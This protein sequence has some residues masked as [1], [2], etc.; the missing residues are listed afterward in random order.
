MEAVDYIK[1]ST[2]Y[3]EPLKLW[4][5]EVYKKNTLITKQEQSLICELIRRKKPKKILE[6]GVHSGGTSAVIL[7][8]IET[9][10]ID[11]K[12]YSVD[13]AEDIG[14]GPVGFVVSSC[15]VHF[16]TQNW[17]LYTGHTIAEVID[18]IGENIDLLVLDAAHILPGEC[19]DFLT[20]YP[21]LSANAMVVTHDIF[22]SSNSY[23]TKDWNATA[24]LY[25]TVVADKYLLIDDSMDPDSRVLCNIGA[26]Q[27]NE[28]TGKYIENIFEGLHLSWFCIPP[29][30]CV[31]A[32]LKIIKENYPFIL[33]DRLFQT[34]HFNLRKRKRETYFDWNKLLNIKQSGT[35]YI[36]IW[37]IK[38]L[39]GRLH[40]TLREYLDDC[41]LKG[42][43]S[44]KNE[45][46]AKLLAS[47]CFVDNNLTN[48]DT[49]LLNS[50]K[51]KNLLKDS[52]NFC[53]VIIGAQS[54]KSRSEILEELGEIKVPK[55][56]IY[57]IEEFIDDNE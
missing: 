27:I 11:S 3:Q 24:V 28:D 46:L 56:K 40:H 1:V 22:L 33:Y 50:L 36:V 54:E 14:R 44:S 35:G 37:G 23:T 31:N 20:V 18:E 13:L 41:R 30:H 38:G 48:Q 34:Y 43:K 53:A 15:G 25:S 12:L 29:E 51:E 9:L 45:T 19:L 4:E 17:T 32:A 10:N 5:N 8:C 6:V 49:L 21:Y 55:E 26:F 2:C 52:K 7:K 57:Y 42:K 39:G 47:I 16:N